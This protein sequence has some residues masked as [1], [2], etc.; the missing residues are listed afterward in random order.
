M[1]RSMFR[2]QEWVFGINH[3]RNEVRVLDPTRGDGVK[4]DN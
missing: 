2:Q 4:K 1:K 3:L